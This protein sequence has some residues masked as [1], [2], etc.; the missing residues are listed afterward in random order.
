[1][2]CKDCIFYCKEKICKNEFVEICTKNKKINS[3]CDYKTTEL[4]SKQSKEKLQSE[5]EKEM[6]LNLLKLSN[7]ND[8]KNDWEL[9]KEFY[10]KK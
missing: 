7:K 10:F 5:I 6:F 2:S 1:M 8:F 3:E 4:E 9:V